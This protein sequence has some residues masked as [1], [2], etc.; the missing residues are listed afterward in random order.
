[1]QRS[2]TVRHMTKRKRSNQRLLKGTVYIFFMMIVA[3][4]G[5]YLW[6]NKDMAPN[7]GDDGHAAVIVPTPSP[8]PSIEPSPVPTS[9]PTPVPSAEPTDGS[10]PAPEPSPSANPAETGTGETVKISFVGDVLLG[11][12]V[13]NLLEQHGY[14]YPYQ[15]VK[16]L[17]QAPD[18][19]VANLETPITTRGTAEDKT[20][21]YRSS[22]DVLPAFKEAGFD[23]VSLANNHTMDYGVVGL[24]D[25]L[26]YLDEEGIHRVGAGRDVE[27]AYR[28]YVWESSGITVAFLSFTRVVSKGSWKAGHG[29]PEGLAETYDHTLAVEA[30]TKAKEQADLVVVLAHWG[31]ERHDDPNDIQIDLARRYIDAGAD[32]IVG[33]HPHVLQGFEQYK[34]KWIAY[35]LGNF[36]FTT[37]DDAPKT[38][39]SSILEATCSKQGCDLQLVP[40]FTK[41]AKPVVMEEQQGR[42]LFRRLTSISRQAEVQDDGRISVKP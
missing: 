40:I 41:W 24:L 34:G 9:E 32:L 5:F 12:T 23:L 31:E 21:A 42:E 22:P 20:F 38:L 11:S 19:T 25:T 7:M 28:P 8:D 4:I 16:S 17:L 36:I 26:D 3:I 27:E 37:R 15:D 35:S 1:M 14:D 30:V 13:N 6:L 18:L 39:D 2:R 29:F 10:S 33:S